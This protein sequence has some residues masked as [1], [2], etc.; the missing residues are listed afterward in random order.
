MPSL[1]SNL[2]GCEQRCSRKAPTQARFTADPG[3]PISCSSLLVA[4]GLKT[5]TTKP[6]NSVIVLLTPR[7]VGIPYVIH[8]L[9]TEDSFISGQREW[10]SMSMHWGG[11]SSIVLEVIVSF[12]TDSLTWAPAKYR[13]PNLGGL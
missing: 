3:Y 6:S 10:G 7:Q 5:I 13:L 2:V 4:Q 8:E 1:V 11:E 9:D 12:T